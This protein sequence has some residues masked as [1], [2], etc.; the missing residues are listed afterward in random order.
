MLGEQHER[1]QVVLRE[2]AA[3]TVDVED[4]EQVAAV[5]QRHAHRA[6]HRVL[7]LDRAEEPAAV[8]GA[9]DEHRLARLGH[10]AGDALAQTHPGVGGELVVADHANRPELVGTVQQHHRAALAVE[11]LARARQD[12]VEHPLEVEHRVDGLPHR[13]ERRQLVE[14]VG[15]RGREHPLFDQQ[16]REAP[17]VHFLLEHVRGKGDGEQD[18]ADAESTKVGHAKALEPDLRVEGDQHHGDRQGGHH[19]E[20]DG[21]QLPAPGLDRLQRRGRELADAHLS[22]FSRDLL[23]LRG[24]AYVS[25]GN[26][27]D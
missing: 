17:E 10:V 9:V 5:G 12:D 8:G 23:A 14:P 16:P 18:H 26:A 27:S 6:R 11:Q 13:A 21:P 7:P 25:T 22:G 24:H 15:E 3:A 19:E 2:H 20:R 1:A 4:A